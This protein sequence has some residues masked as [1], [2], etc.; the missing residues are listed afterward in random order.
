MVYAGYRFNDRFIF[1]SEIEIEH[2]NEIFLECTY[3]DWRSSDN[4]GLRA[5]MLLMPAGVVNE[6]HEPNVVL[7]A[8]RPVTER[9]IIPSTWR[10]N[11]VGIYGSTG[12][13][14]YRAYVVN[15]FRGDSRENV[16]IF[17]L[18]NALG[19]EEG[20]ASADTPPT[21]H[22]P[23]PPTSWTSP[24]PRSTASASRST[25]PGG[26]TGGRSATRDSRARTGLI[27]PPR[28][29]GTAATESPQSPR[30]GTP[31]RLV[32]ETAAAV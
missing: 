20:G 18:A 26:S 15:G 10:E 19:G 29:A 16:T 12:R 9:I 4:Q 11:G 17:I 30:R 22:P 24:P 2:A 32:R 7:G 28:D 8:E 25:R 1:N 3:L 5:G 6:L 31:N 23:S 13:V 14:S 27:R 21:A